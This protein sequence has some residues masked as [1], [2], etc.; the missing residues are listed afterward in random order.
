MNICRRWRQTAL[1]PIPG[2]KLGDPNGHT[3]QINQ[4]RIARHNPQL[5]TA[6]I[7][8]KAR[9]SAAINN[10]S[11]PLPIRACLDQHVVR[12]ATQ[13][14]WDTLNNGDLLA[15]AEEGGFIGPGTVRL[16]IGLEDADDLIGDIDQ[17]LRAA[18]GS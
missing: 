8:R 11:T 18:T 5:K 2:E 16:S 7:A 9:V 13:Q 12:T 3:D 6:P 17:A 10:T 15:A 1:L 14:G 4:Q